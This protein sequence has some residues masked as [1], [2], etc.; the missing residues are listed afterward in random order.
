MIGIILAGGNGTRFSGTGCCKPL[1]TVNG[2][3]LIEYA[4]ENLISLKV[5]KVVIVVGKYKNEIINAIGSN[6]K[7]LSVY[8]AFQNTPAGIINALYQALSYWNGETVVLQLSDEIYVRF[9]PEALGAADDAD[10]LCGYTVVEEKEIIKENYSIHCA[11]RGERLLSCEEK[12]KLVHNNKKGTGF[13]VFGPQCIRLLKERYEDALD[14]FVTLCDFMNI[15]IAEGL[16]GVAVQIAD[17][18]ININTTDKLK[19]AEYVLKR[20]NENE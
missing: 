2:K 16:C 15:L 11:G 7:G 5:D 9:C 18:E 20:E 3:R 4:L 19:Y 6:Y 14:H 12:P 1:L 8:Y 17:E 10:F 13:C